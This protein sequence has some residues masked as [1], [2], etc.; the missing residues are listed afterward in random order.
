MLDLNLGADTDH[1]H[2]EIL[3]VSAQPLYA[4]TGTVPCHI[5]PN[6]SF[7]NHHAVPRYIV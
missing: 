2:T 3:R 7:I 4:N 5:L 6:S 1:H